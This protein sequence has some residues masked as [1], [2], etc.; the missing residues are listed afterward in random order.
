MVDLSTPKDILYEKPPVGSTFFLAIHCLRRNLQ[1]ARGS[2]EDQYDGRKDRD[3]AS[4]RHCMCKWSY[5]LELALFS[6]ETYL[7][8]A[9]WDTNNR[10]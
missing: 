9:D 6:F 8:L 10:L 7:L 3:R 1:K 2:S 5:F 4:P